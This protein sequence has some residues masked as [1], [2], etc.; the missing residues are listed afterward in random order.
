MYTLTRTL[1]LHAGFLVATFSFGR[2]VVTTRTGIMCDRY[3]HRFTLLFAGVF[4]T[5]GSL[6]WG[7]SPSLGGLPT[8]FLAQFLLGVGT[9]T[10]GVSRS[11]VAERVVPT[12]RTNALSR[13]AALQYAGFSMTPLCGSSLVI[14]GRSISSFWEYTLP[15]LF[16]CLLSLINM[17]LLFFVFK[18]ITKEQ[19]LGLKLQEVTGIEVKE[20]ADTASGRQDSVSSMAS[21]SSVSNRC[22]LMLRSLNR[23]AAD[24][25]PIEAISVVH[26]TVGAVS[27]PIEPSLHPIDVVTTPLDHSPSMDEEASTKKFTADKDE[28]GEYS[29]FGSKQNMISCLLIF[30]NFTT[31][32]GVA[33]YETQSTRVFL[34]D[35]GFSYLFLG[36][37]VSSAG[38]VGTLNLVY[39]KYMWTDTYR[40]VALILGGLVAMSVAQLLVVN[41][42]RHEASLAQFCCALSLVYS[43]GFPISNTATLGSFGNVQK[44]GRQAAAQSRFALAASLAR[45]LMPILSGVM[46]QYLK[47]NCSFSVVL[48]LVAASVLMVL[49]K[50]DELCELSNRNVGS[51]HGTPT[52]KVPILDSRHLRRWLLSCSAAMCVAGAATLVQGALW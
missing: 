10:L 25:E 27:Q 35:F 9:S 19:S 22:S 37:L 24:L 32:G 40:D 16:L 28:A 47:K 29:F 1:L 41:W 20:D 46:E 30:L 8:L 21:E 15:A 18:D 50:Y 11:Y 7:F 14:L 42:S 31:R 4:I 38:L 51:S 36:A 5:I 52:D 2:A 12:K 48:L 33:V 17:L 6:L 39:F 43:F 26:G 34:D 49:N 45:I 3:R 23:Y 13:L 44:L